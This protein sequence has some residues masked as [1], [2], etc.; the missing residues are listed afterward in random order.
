[1]VEESECSDREKK[2]QLMESLKGPALEIV[3][4]VR[5]RNPD[6]NP[7][8]YLEALD[9]AFGTAESGDDLY[10]SFRLMQQQ[11]DEKLSDFLRR[12]ERSLS[13]VV[14]RGGLQS[15]YQDRARVEQLLRGSVSSDLMLIQLCVRERKT[16]PLTFLQLLS[17]I[18]AEEEYEASRMKLNT[19]GHQVQV[20]QSSVVR[21]T[22]IQ[23]L[24]AE[25]K[26]LRS[27]VASVWAN[28]TATTEDYVDPVPANT[29]SSCEKQQDS[30]LAA[31]K[32]QVKRLQQKLNQKVNASDS[33][34]TATKVSTVEA[35]RVVNSPAR[36]T[37]CTEE[38]FCYTCGEN[39]HGHNR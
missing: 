7:A 35:T 36:P 10:F 2:R 15:S 25:I 24:K 12:L 20:K 26:E 16:K 21:T 32:K 8:K 22:E 33:T 39:G 13:K 19:S 11:P 23:S 4:A 30:E 29:S 18:R 9:S 6:A 28:S 37:R 14:Q 1:M 34:A 31:L 5:A 27:M 3:K 17:E 38:Q